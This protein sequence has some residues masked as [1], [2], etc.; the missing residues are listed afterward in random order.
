MNRSTFIKSLVGLAV[1]PLLPKIPIGK[2]IEPSPSNWHENDAY[3][4][5]MIG[6]NP[7]KVI[8][9]EGWYRHNLRPWVSVSDINIEQAVNNLYNGN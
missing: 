8:V 5:I 9:G 1:T 4:K 2:Y 3:S 6:D 7:I